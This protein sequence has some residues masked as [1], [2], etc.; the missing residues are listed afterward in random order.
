MRRE[1]PLELERL[2]A[3]SETTDFDGAAQRR[4]GRIFWPLC[5]VATVILALGLVWFLTLE[6]RSRGQKE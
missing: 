1:H 5:V 3:G 6:G 2:L 4:R